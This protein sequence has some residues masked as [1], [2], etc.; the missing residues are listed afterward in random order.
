MTHYL[1]ELSNF[2]LEASQADDKPDQTRSEKVFVFNPRLHL[3]ELLMGFEPMTSS[4][5][6]TRS[7]N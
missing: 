2:S 4:L 5:P 7:T 6:R 1:E 3:P